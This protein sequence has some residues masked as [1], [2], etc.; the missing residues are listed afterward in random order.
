M[1][2]MGRAPDEVLGYILL[3]GSLV[4]IGCYF[5]LVFISPWAQ[6]VVQVSAFL[7]VTAVL[8]VM[9]WIGYTLTITS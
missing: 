7:A 6:L 2:K 4:G 8:A 1:S 5:Y 9:A 3:V